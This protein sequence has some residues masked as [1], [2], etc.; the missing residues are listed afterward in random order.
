MHLLCNF[1]STSP[2]NALI[3][4]FAY[5]KLRNAQN[6]C[7]DVDKKNEKAHTLFTSMPYAIYQ[8]EQSFESP[9]TKLSCSSSVPLAAAPLSGVLSKAVKTLLAAAVMWDRLSF[10]SSGSGF[11]G[12]ESPDVALL[13]RM[14]LPGKVCWGRT[15]IGLEAHACIDTPQ[16]LHPVLPSVSVFQTSRL[17]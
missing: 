15:G 6:P 4:M 16:K 2:C 9:P 3:V 10:S 8:K 14:T 1:A 12:G 11:T 5:F 17:A 13:E 7:K